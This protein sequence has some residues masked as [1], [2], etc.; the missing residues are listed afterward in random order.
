MSCPNGVKR[1]LKC[2]SLF[3]AAQLPELHFEYLLDVLVIVRWLRAC[4]VCGA[5]HEYLNCAEENYSG[6]DAEFERL[7]ILFL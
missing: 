4:M 3:A 7:R 1:E 6:P 5:E 2:R